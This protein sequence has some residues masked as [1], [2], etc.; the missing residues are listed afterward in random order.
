M[1]RKRVQWSGVTEI[2]ARMGVYQGDLQAELQDF[3]NRWA[4]VLEAYAKEN[5]PWTDRTG[6]A[7]QGLRG[8]SSTNETG[9]GVTVELKGGVHYQIYLEVSNAG[10]YAIILPTLE[11]HYNQMIADLKERFDGGN[12]T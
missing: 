5:R 6:N 2:V 10:K 3:G 9:D 7:R 1:A 8:D 11:A 12:S 4:P